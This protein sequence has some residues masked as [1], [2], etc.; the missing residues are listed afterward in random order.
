M[1]FALQI[2]AAFKKS[3]PA[4]KTPL[5]KKVRREGCFWEEFRYDWWWW[6]FRR[7]KKFSSFPQRKSEK[8][9]FLVQKRGKK[10]TKNALGARVVL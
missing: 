3:A 2:N 6:I 5:V 4:K 7:Y 9:E 1:A 10:K 8:R